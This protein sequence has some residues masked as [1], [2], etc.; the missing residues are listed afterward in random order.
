MSHTFNHNYFLS[1]TQLFKRFY[2][3]YFYT[4]LNDEECVHARALCASYCFDCARGG[5]LASGDN[6]Y[7]LFAM[8]SLVAVRVGGGANG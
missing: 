5:Q 6:H 8:L 2:L 1:E 3:T 4:H 7:Q